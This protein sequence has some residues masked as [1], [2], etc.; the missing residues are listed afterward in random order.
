MTGGCEC[1]THCTYNNLCTCN[2]VDPPPY[3]DCDG[4]AE[5]CI[6]QIVDGAPYTWFVQE[7]PCNVQYSCN[8]YYS[9]T[10]YETTCTC[11]ISNCS[12]ESNCFCNTV[13]SCNIV[14]TYG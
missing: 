10:Y 6:Y 4:S 1:N 2:I 14:T 8:P 5:G 9:G 13:C 3:C 7:C 11:N 12:C